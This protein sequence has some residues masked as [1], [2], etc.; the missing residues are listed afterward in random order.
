MAPLTGER[1]RHDK[2]LP[3]ARRA[4]PFTAKTL[5][6][7]AVL[8]AKKT[9]APAPPPP[10][11][12]YIETDGKVFLE[13]R[14]GRLDLPTEKSL[15]P[16]R[17]ET[18]PGFKALGREVLFG[19]PVL[20]AHPEEWTEKERVVASDGA[21]PLARA[22]VLATMHRLVTNAVVMDGARVL[23]CKA[24]RGV[25][26]G[27]WNLPGGFVEWD[28]HPWACTARELKEELG[29]EAESG[30]LLT[31]SSRVFERSG[32]FMVCF[33][34]LVTVKSKVLRLDRTEIEEAAW[35]TLDKAAAETRNPFAKEAFALLLQSAKPSQK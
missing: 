17:V 20:D 12:L 14:D 7:A 28:E 15:L 35:F 21:T 4:N 11:A 13:E 5:H 30:R 34:Y 31:V 6:A 10:R 29:V 2:G 18:R 3:R 16:F 25:A 27:W 22:A 24:N 32:Y 23:M 33:V 26:K 19:R 9:S 8:R 1:A